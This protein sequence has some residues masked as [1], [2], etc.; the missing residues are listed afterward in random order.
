MGDLAT[1]F[2]AWA[3]GNH[4]WLEGLYIFLPLYNDGGWQKRRSKIDKLKAA[5]CFEAH[6]PSKVP[7]RQS[8]ITHEP[9][10]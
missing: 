6:F 1:R 3:F 10:T 7:S 5:S 8:I 9:S 2:T 4:E